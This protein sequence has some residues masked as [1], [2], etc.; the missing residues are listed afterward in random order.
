MALV[1]LDCFK[2][3]ND[4]MGH[5]AGDSVLLAVT[6]RILQCLRASDLLSRYGGDEFAIL[7]PQTDKEGAVEV[8]ERIRTAVASS[9][10]DVDDQAIQLSISLGLATWDATEGADRRQLLK[11]ADKALYQAKAQGRNRVAAWKGL[12]SFRK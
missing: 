10:L 3:I 5:H 9:T 12:A 2:A 4:Q 6:A 11:R 1:D 8:A 7:L